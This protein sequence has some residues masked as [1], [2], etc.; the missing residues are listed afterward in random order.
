MR[1]DDVH[2]AADAIRQDPV[3]KNATFA[4]GC[5]WSVEEAFRRV[6]GVVD[7]TVGYTGGTLANPT[8]ERVCTGNTGHAESVLITYNPAMVSY[9]TLLDVF[10][11]SHDPTQL[12][13]QG[14]DVGPQYRSAIFYHDSEQ[15]GKAMRSRAQLESTGRYSRPIVTE[16]KGAATFWPAEEYHQQYLEKRRGHRR[17]VG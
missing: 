9:E 11:A 15:K 7:V 5:F 17:C 3:L 6:P 4:A 1:S 10:W 13:R 8:Y 12:N 14:P 16:I 2:G